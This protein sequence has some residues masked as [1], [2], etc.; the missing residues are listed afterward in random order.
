MQIHICSTSVFCKSMLSSIHA[1][2]CF[3]PQK[4]RKAPHQKFATSMIRNFVAK[5][6]VS[7]IFGETKYLL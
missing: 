5:V 4:I 1:T 7:M 2:F 6:E 3:C